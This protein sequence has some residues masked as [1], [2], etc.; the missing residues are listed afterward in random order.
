MTV[1]ARKKGR[2]TMKNYNGSQIILEF[3]PTFE[4]KFKVL[5]YDP[6]DFIVDSGSSLG[7]WVGQYQFK[8]FGMIR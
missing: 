3:N 7:L 1:I 5:S 4:F 6:F 8:F 2:T